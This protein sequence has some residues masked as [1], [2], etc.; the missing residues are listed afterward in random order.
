VGVLLRGVFMG[1]KHAAIAM[2]KH[3]CGSI[4]NTASIAGL[5]TGFGGHTYSAC[6]AAVIHLTRSVA[7]ELGEFGIR[8]NSICPGAIATPIFA[9]TFGLEHADALK[10]IAPLKE[11]FASVAALGR[12]GYPED[13]AKAALFLAGDDA[14]FIS[15]EELKVDGGIGGRFL[16]D[17]QT[18]VQMSAALGIDP[19]LFPL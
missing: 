18:K 8:V 12:S 1:I 11:M 13:V 4:I 7:M 9:K 17:E 19:S 14:G 15:G 10:S 6:K 5:Q 3:R 2:K 16:G